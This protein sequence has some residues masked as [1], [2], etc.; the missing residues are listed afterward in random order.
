MWILISHHDLVSIIVLQQQVSYSGTLG[1]TNP[2]MEVHDP[3]AMGSQ[4]GTV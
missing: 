1:Y 3:T 2:E 4:E